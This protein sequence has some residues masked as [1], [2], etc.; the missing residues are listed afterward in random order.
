MLPKTYRKLIADHFS[1]NFREVAKI[2]EAELKPPT[3][4]ELTIRNMYAGVNAT[5][6]N[7][8]AGLYTPGATPPI[9]LGAEIIGEV[10]AI[11][12]NVTDYKVGDLVVSTAIGGYA[13]YVTVRSRFV[14]PVPEA[15]PEMVALVMS[16]VTATLGLNTVGEMRSDETVLVTAAA[17]GT[18]QFAV[19]LA[20]LAGNTVIGT[21]GSPDKAELLKTLGCDR[22]INYK[23]EHVGAV[24]KAE[25]PQGINLVYESVGG[26]MFDTC[27]ENLAVR[28][29]LV[30][31][32]YIS[33]YLA[34]PELVT[35]PR[36]YRILL[37][38]SASLRAMFLLHF[39]RQI[40]GEMAKLVESYQAGKLK[41]EVDPKAFNGVEQVADAVD[42]L[43]TGKSAGKVV[44][45]FS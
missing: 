2:V 42:Y 32:G 8:S 38:K 21:C 22:V 28:G 19:Q 20:K 5:D 36:I 13:E 34:K 27:V 35:R 11:G 40:P 18:G 10:V 24:L 14:I 17:G 15:T 4:F 26:T 25:Y 30:I 16:G 23:Q 9:D 31:I 29:R 7:I 41:V 6:V 39:I 45:K 1:N 12:D 43:H 37:S 44:V 3:G 33:E